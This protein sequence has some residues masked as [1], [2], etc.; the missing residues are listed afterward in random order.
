MDNFTCLFVVVWF[1]FWTG[2]GGAGGAMAGGWWWLLFVVVFV[3]FGVEV[4]DEVVVC[5]EDY[6]FW[7]GGRGWGHFYVCLCR[8]VTL[9]DVSVIGCREYER[10]CLSQVVLSWRSDDIQL[11]E[12]CYCYAVDPAMHLIWDLNCSVLVLCTCVLPFVMSIG[13]IWTLGAWAFDLILI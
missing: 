10:G 4:F 3:V 13:L 12:Y 11:L 6:F 2:E 1:V 5:V 9:V 8:C 7:W